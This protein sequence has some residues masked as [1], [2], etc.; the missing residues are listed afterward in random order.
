MVKRKS[1]KNMKAHQARFKAA[2]KKCKLAGYKYFTK[3]F[4][5]C[6]KKELKK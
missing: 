1:S 3:P 6:V 5:A 4:G 2:A